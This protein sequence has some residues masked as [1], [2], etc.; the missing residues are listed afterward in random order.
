MIIEF[1]YA[2]DIDFLSHCVDNMQHIVNLF[3]S[4]CA[5]FGLKKKLGK[6]SDP[7]IKPL[8]HII[9]LSCWFVFY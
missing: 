6:S 2:E 3:A 4:S 7:Y 9:V 1:L 8:G 5:V